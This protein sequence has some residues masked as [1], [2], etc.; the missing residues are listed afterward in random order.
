[1]HSTDPEVQRW[2]LSAL[3]ELL[4]VERLGVKS[5]HFQRLIENATETKT[6]AIYCINKNKIRNKKY[7]EKKRE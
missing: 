5:D 7:N 1:M 4:K 2:A 6:Q 3:T